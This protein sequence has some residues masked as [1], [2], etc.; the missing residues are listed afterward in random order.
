MSRGCAV[1]VYL[2]SDDVRDPRTH[3]SVYFSRSPIEFPYRS[4]GNNG[5][6]FDVD[7][8]FVQY[9]NN[10]N[11]R[12]RSHSVKAYNPWIG[13]PYISIDDQKFYLDE[14]EVQDKWDNPSHDSTRGQA[15]YYTVKR[16]SDSDDYKEYELH[17]RR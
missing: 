3:W 16:L 2:S 8:D 11:S 15:I 13:K 4:A 17:I 5:G 14:G 10:S 12:V 7:E 1:T 9:W 6:D